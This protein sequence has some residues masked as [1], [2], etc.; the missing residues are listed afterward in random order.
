MG[1]I[2]SMKK[3]WGPERTL[4]GGGKLPQGNARAKENLKFIGK[5]RK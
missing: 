2:V 3:N 4:Y 1:N 5:K